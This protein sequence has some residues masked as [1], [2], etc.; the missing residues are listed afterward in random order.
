MRK[1]RSEP[2]LVQKAYSTVDGFD[3]VFIRLQQQVTLRGQSKS[4]LNNYIR[5]VKILK[6]VVDK[7]KENPLKAL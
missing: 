4:T 7:M 3:K 6:K 1:Q 5:R 2:T